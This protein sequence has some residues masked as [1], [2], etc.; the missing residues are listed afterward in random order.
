[1]IVILGGGGG[2]KKSVL[3][4]VV[5]L[6][7][8]G[9]SCAQQEDTQEPS[10]E[11]SIA[12]GDV[13]ESVRGNVVTIPVNVKGLKIVKADGDT[14]G[15]SGHFH[16]FSGGVVDVGETIPTG[17]G[18]VHT[19]DNPIKIYGQ[20]PGKHTFQIVVGDGTH[21]RFGE[22]LFLETTVDVKGPSV[23]GD[24][25]PTID[26]GEDLE[27]DLRA[28]GVEIVKAD[29]DDSGETGHFHVI[30]DSASPPKA[31]RPIPPAGS[32]PPRP[33]SGLPY[34]EQFIHTPESSATVSDLAKGEHT[35][36]VVLGDGNHRAFEPAVMDKLTVTVA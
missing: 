5:G 31:G 4:L 17:P 13:A 21:K 15:E 16:V 8:V 33:G 36:W 19:A 22:E 29:G 11:Q 28:E 26:A 1:V 20:G 2:M 23:F 24:A 6:I 7:L 18:I 12:L 3:S 10:T 27:V 30:V 14:S 34:R 9:A 35:I 32:R 25:P